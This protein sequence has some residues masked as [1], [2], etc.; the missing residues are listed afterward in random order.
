METQDLIPPITWKRSKDIKSRKYGEYITST[1][2]IYLAWL[3]VNETMDLKRVQR[4]MQKL[5]C[6][7][8]A[9]VA[10][11]HN[12]PGPKDGDYLLYRCRAS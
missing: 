9:V 10:L 4:L 6:K 3:R 11:F 5:C 2:M 7:K 1:D 12:G 8:Q